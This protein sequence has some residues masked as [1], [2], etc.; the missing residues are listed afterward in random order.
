MCFVHVEKALDRVDDEQERLVKSNCKSGYEMEQRQKL[1]RYQ[2]NL[3]NFWCKVVYI[4]NL[5]FRL[6]FAIEVG[7][8]SKH[9]RK[10]LIN[11]ILY[12]GD[13]GFNE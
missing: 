3:N 8:I 6:W 5:Y 11:E 2:S 10:G 9:A 4:K 1:A 13:F 12:A 7:V